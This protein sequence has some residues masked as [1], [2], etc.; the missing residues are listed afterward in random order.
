[1]TE[2]KNGLS[3]G[4]A[5]NEMAPQEDGTKVPLTDEAGQVKFSSNPPNGDAKIDISDGP[6]FS[7][8]TKNELM[9]YADD[10]FWVRLRWVLFFIF[11]GGWLAM[12]VMAIVIIIQAPRCAPKETLEWVQESAMVQLYMKVPVDPNGDGTF[13]PQDVVMM[14]K[15]LG[16]TTVYLE[17]LI[18]GQDFEKLNR[19]Y[20]NTDVLAVLK[21]A[22]EA[23]LHVV[24][25]FVPSTVDQ[26]NVW[27]TN[28]SFSDFFIP[29]T[30][31]LDFSNEGLLD[32]LTE[33]FSTTW[34]SRGVLGY[35]VE[36]ENV[37]ETLKNATVTITQGLAE[38]DGAVVYGA[39]DVNRE[40][41][42]FTPEL[43][44]DFLDQHIDNWAYYK[45]NPRLAEATSD[46]DSKAKAKLVT[47]TLFLVPGT[48]LL[49]GIQTDYFNAEKGFIKSLSEF[50]GKESVQVGDMTFVNSTSEDVI[51][52]AR[53]MKG[54]PG[55]AVAVN[56]HPSNST[57]VDFQSIAGVPEKGDMR[58]KISNGNY[59]GGELGRA[60]L[61]RVVLE[62]LQ[63]VVV[64]FVP[65]LD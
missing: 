3:H 65:N 22:N 54:T 23:N 42:T 32:K 12:L 5:N 9:K 43:F 15:E 7:G 31:T 30:R 57:E 36:D 18:S 34:N 40:L 27:V 25:D 60:E 33:I 51:A 49:Q 38:E 6:T 62:P 14:A 61:S 48:P 56:F 55:C 20:D 47:M 58:I 64:L 59:T 29:G 63:G 21:A 10:P 44:K 19:I 8:L 45:F 11:W 37:D 13:D 16:V 50:R 2:E 24:T 52:F 46:P 28:T 1:M 35:L 39:T 41:N 53:V 4:P 17:D 26:N